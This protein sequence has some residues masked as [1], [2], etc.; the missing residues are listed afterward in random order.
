MLP[1]IPCSSASRRRA[2][3][4]LL[5]S[6]REPKTKRN[7]TTRSATTAPARARRKNA[8]RAPLFGDEMTPSASSRVWLGGSVENR[9]QAS[10]SSDERTV[11]RWLV[12]LKRKRRSHQSAKPV[13]PAWHECSVE[14]LPQSFSRFPFMA[15]HGVSRQC[16]KQWAT[17]RRNL[18][19]STQ[20]G[21]RSSECLS[22]CHRVLP[23]DWTGV[24]LLMA[25][26]PY[27]TASLLKGT[28][29]TRSSESLAW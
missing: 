28:G 12:T 6:P 16:A 8:L 1:A 25:L 29:P 10:H 15:P 5:L 27:S 20:N 13:A 11:R 14:Q 26:L 24:S 23:S 2:V 21:V 19:N 4:S 9:L 17:G 7:V 3:H 22:G 18:R